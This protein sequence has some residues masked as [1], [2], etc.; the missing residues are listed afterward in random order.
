MD[1]VRCLCSG[2][3]VAVGT[4]L[5]AGVADA[6]EL[7]NLSIEDI[8]ATY[9]YAP[10][11]GV[12]GVLELNETNV[13]FVAEL[14]DDTVIAGLADIFLSLELTAEIGDPNDEVGHGLFGPGL[15]TL[16]QN[17][18]NPDPLDI[19]FQA[20]IDAGFE[21]F[22][23]SGDTGAFQGAGTF[24][25]AV[26]G[27]DLDG[28]THPVAGQVFA[29]LFTWYADEAKTQPINLK[30]YTTA[31][32]PGTTIYGDMTLDVVPEPSVL[33]SMVALMPW[34]IRRRRSTG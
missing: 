31:Q 26:Y 25:S 23:I 4:M 16:T 29:L 34:A 9:T 27:A 30:N 24:S 2:V 32:E 22:E 14:T 3:I 15:L 8:D 5:S 28:V 12:L 13:A 33:I 7:R 21:L 11:Q 17:G 19:L 10:E 1:Y 18:G 6:A 20:D